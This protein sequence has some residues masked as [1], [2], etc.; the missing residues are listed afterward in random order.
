MTLSPPLNVPVEPP[1][2]T[3]ANRAKQLTIPMLIIQQPTPVSSPS[4]EYPGSP[5]PHKE[6]PPSRMMLKDMEKP[7]SLDLPAPPPVITV[8]CMSDS[9]T[10]SATTKN[11]TD[12]SKNGGGMCYLSPFSMCSR[13]DRIASESNL[14][15]SGYSSGPSRCNSN[16]RLCSLDGSEEP[17]RPRL[18]P[19]IHTPQIKEPGTMDS[20]TT[21]SENED[22]GFDTE[23]TDHTAGPLLEGNDSKTTGGMIRGKHYWGGLG[24]TGGCSE[25]ETETPRPLSAGGLELD[26]T[27]GR[28]HP[29]QQSL[30]SIKVQQYPST[31]HLSTDM[32]Q[33]KSP[34]SSRSES[35]LSDKT[36]FRFS[37]MF[38]G[39][40]TESD[41]IYDFTS[42]DCAAIKKRTGKKRERKKR[43][44]AFS[45]G[46]S[47]CA[48]PVSETINLTCGDGNG[49]NSL[50]LD[51]P[52]RNNKK[53]S[54]SKPNTRRRSRSQQTVLPSS[55]SSTDSLN[56]RTK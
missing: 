26:S 2:A 10:E 55:S 44:Y 9:D 43:H 3:S 34:V 51:V 4:I 15:S 27:H 46:L 35:P 16:T 32:L 53:K 13:A 39:R 37:P 1:A 22:E 33:D 11:G 36:V 14:S 41:S 45:G 42:S 24:G 52:G 12:S 18:S 38:Y 6:K 28:H 48:T 54:R 23:T 7:I 8:T 56:N 20:E 31:L 50:L 30:P 29:Q 19:L 5:P 17:T 49:S 21:F 25:L 47:P 40:V